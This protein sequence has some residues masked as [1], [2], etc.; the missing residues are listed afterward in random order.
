MKLFLL[1]LALAALPALSEPRV[2]RAAPITLYT[3]FLQ[4]N[5][6]PA[7]LEAL[8]DELAGIMTPIGLRFDW[9]SLAA[10]EGREVSVELAVITFR[11]G[12]DVENLAP[13]SAMPGAL[14]WTHV[15]DGAILPF[16]EIDCD[17]IRHFLQGDLLHVRKED[18]EEVF[19]RALARVLAHELY[20]IFANTQQHGSWGVGK[21]AYSIQELLSHTFRFE[22][23]ETNALRAGKAKALLDTP[24]EGQ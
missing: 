13:F 22:H 1:G 3:N 4:Q 21:A 6:P 14:G 11:G 23:R 20:H 5:P 8:Q 17:G 15:S 19:G 2:I 10:S 24:G 9:R 7:V 12:C 18:R 16:S